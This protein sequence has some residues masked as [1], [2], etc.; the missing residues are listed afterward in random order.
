MTAPGPTRP[1]PG[2]AAYAA[3]PAAALWALLLIGLLVMLPCAGTA[4]AA[5]PHSAPNSAPTASA[6]PQAKDAPPAAAPAPVSTFP[7]T[8]CSADDL[9]P[10][11][12]DGCSSH[13]F[14]GQDAQLP[15]AP[16]QPLPAT[17]PELVTVGAAPAAEAPVTVPG[18]ATATD[19]HLLQVNRT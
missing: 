14:D 15:N 5:V 19:L 1:E 17:L 13:H 7:L 11:P 9:G 2:S 10:R 12:G 4:R 8:W 3:R 18:T 6:H 16:P